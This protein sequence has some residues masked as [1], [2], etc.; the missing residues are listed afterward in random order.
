MSSA[1]GGTLARAGLLVAAATVLFAGFG[2]W[3]ASDGVT[4]FKK[5]TYVQAEDPKGFRRALVV[6]YGFTCILGT[7]GSVA[8]LSGALAQR[9]ARRS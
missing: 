8:L 4:R 2:V 9:L 6:R 3:D 5:W 1:A 7:V